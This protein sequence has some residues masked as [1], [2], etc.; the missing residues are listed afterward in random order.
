MVE[1]KYGLTLVQAINVI[2][3][4][5]DEEGSEPE[6][7]PEVESSADSDDSSEGNPRVNAVN[8]EYEDS[9]DDIPFILPFSPNE[10]ERPQ[11]SEPIPPANNVDSTQTERDTKPKSSDEASTAGEDIKQTHQLSET[12]EKLIQA[13]LNCPTQAIQRLG[14]EPERLDKLLTDEQIYLY[15]V[16]E[17]KVRKK[18]HQSFPATAIWTQHHPKPLGLT[19]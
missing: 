12:T 8:I 9:D 2:E 18:D 15:A 1:T 10:T 5:E 19:I 11:G 7:S 4:Q 6:R 3:D 17:E 16:L 14:Y 13:A